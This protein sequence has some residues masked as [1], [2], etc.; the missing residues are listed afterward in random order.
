MRSVSLFAVVFLVVVL[1]MAMTGPAY[2]TVTTITP[3]SG[4]TYISQLQ[5]DTNFG[6][7][8]SLLVYSATAPPPAN[9]RSLVK[10]DLSSVPSGSTVNSASLQLYRYSDIGAS[11]VGRTYTA[12]R[13]IT[14][15]WAEASATWNKYD[16]VNS[17]GSPGG[18][19]TTAGEASATVPACCGYIS[20]TVTDIVKAW[21]ESD[22]PNYGF[23]IKDQVED[24][25]PAVGAWFFSRESTDPNKPIL[26]VDY[27]APIAAVGGVVIPV[28]TLAIVAPWLAVIGLVGCIGTIVAVR[29]KRHP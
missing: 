16:G 24:A 22:Q 26:T 28:D 1:A 4:D 23:L 19:F 6:T 8:L 12:D 3:S 20:W 29:R 2:A 14:S 15:N 7:L 5:P 9:V 27:T 21:I 18:D 25:S 17:W 11:P 13:V 10:F